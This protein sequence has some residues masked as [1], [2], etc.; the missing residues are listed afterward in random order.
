MKLLLKIIIGLLNLIFLLMK[1]L[2]VQNKI[3]YI[4]R[5]YNAK[6][7]DMELLEDALSRFENAPKQVFLCKKLEEGVVCK[8]F[9]CFHIFRQ[10]YHIATSQVVILDSYCIAVSVLK[11]RETVK[12]IQMWHALGALKKFGF[13]IV[14]EG[15]GSSR[16]IADIMRMHKNYSY[17]LTSGE[18]CVPHFASAFGYGR[19]KIKVLPLPRVDKLTDI[20]SQ[21][22]IKESIYNRYPQ[23]RGKKIVLYAPTFRKEKD[24][25]KDIEAISEQFSDDEYIFVLK[26]HPLMKKEKVSCLEDSEFSTIDMISAADYVIC[27]YSAVIFE[28][29]VLKKPL[30]FYIFDYESYCSNRDFYINYMEE[31]PGVISKSP[32]EIGLAIRNN[33]YNLSRVE[34]FSHKYVECQENC[35]YKIAEMIM[36]I[37]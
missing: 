9:Y 13:S 18:V 10:M 29:A 4:S 2:P 3:T 1:L 16:E 15:E 20:D 25:S 7:E 35:S 5:Q 8:F 26:R 6:S 28:A 34:A 12:V 19:E 23:F 36:Q 27:D 31:M 32:Q 22:K 14:G 17:I 21:K 24:I 30:F 33:D 37:I 11:Q